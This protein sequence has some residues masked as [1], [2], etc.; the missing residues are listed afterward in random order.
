MK[1]DIRLELKKV[2]VASEPIKE[3]D[4]IRINDNL[5]LVLSVS[6]RLEV[7]TREANNI[8]LS[9]AYYQMLSPNIIDIET[10]I[11]EWYYRNRN[12]EKHKEQYDKIDAILKEAGL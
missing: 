1:R 11:K 4:K 3:R 10:G 6:S 7:V 2:L 8:S 5:S 9:R 12:E